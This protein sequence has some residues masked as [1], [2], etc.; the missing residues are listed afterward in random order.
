MP[1]MEDGGKKLLKKN[2]KNIFATN[3]NSLIKYAKIV[4]I[5]IGTPVKN[6]KPDL[7][8]FFKMFKN[9]KSELNPKNLLVIRSS[10]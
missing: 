3:D 5:C 4:I 7:L 1:Y 10:I 9:I 2:K 8:N 6:S